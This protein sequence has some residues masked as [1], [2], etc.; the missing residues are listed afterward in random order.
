MANKD[1]EWILIVPVDKEDNKP[2][3]YWSKLYQYVKTW[4]EMNSRKCQ[5]YITVGGKTENLTDYY[6]CYMQAIESIERSY[7]PFSVILVLLYL[8]N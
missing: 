4:I 2:K 8:M 5:V 3:V 7:K 6:V 1:G